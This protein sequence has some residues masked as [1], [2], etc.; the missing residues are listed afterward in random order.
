MHRKPRLRTR[1]IGFTL[2]ELLVVISI[3][4]LLI[5]LLL[6]ALGAVLRTARTVK[7]TGK[8]REM[9]LAV[10]A[11]GQSNDQM[12]PFAHIKGQ[13][14]DDTWATIL[15]NED[16][17]TARESGA[18][19]DPKKSSFH[20]PEAPLDK[21]PADPF[22]KPHQQKSTT[23][24]KDWYVWNFY[25]VNGTAG[26]SGSVKETSMAWPFYAIGSGWAPMYVY[27]E[28]RQTSADDPARLIMFYDGYYLHDS[29]QSYADRVHARHGTGYQTNFVALDGASHTDDRENLIT[30]GGIGFFWSHRNAPLVNGFYY[31]GFRG[32]GD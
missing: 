29:N 23:Q 11:Y 27:E 9:V 16:Y 28:T 19:D 22:M 7:C 31:R 17:L 14:G 6:P 26:R 15:V 12:F 1:P 24:G 13:G 10:K 2:I 21:N 5:A 8:L 3:I 4:A 30:T 18:G 25:G 20:C 32:W